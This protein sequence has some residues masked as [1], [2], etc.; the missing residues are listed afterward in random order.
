MLVIPFLLFSTE[1]IRACFRSILRAHS[2]L[3][4]A[5]LH[6]NVYSLERGSLDDL[7]FIENRDQ[8]RGKYRAVLG[9]LV[10]DWTVLFGRS[11]R[12]R[13]GAGRILTKDLTSKF[14]RLLSKNLSF[15]LIRGS[16]TRQG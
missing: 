1:G 12:Q 2:L 9:F 7:H 5:G 3:N 4:R 10:V 16:S 13:L 11:F 6:L 15:P 8:F 14:L